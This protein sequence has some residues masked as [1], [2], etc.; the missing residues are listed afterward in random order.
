[1]GDSFRKKYKSKSGIRAFGFARPEKSTKKLRT[2][3]PLLEPLFVRG[4]KSMKGRIKK[5]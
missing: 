4:I 3:S 5:G 2:P 1:M